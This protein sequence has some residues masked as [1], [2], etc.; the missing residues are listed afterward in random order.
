MLHHRYR[1]TFVGFDPADTN[2]WYRCIPS[3]G[4]GGGAWVLVS[5]VSVAVSA[6]K[7]L[8]I[9][10]QNF[11]IL[12]N[13]TNFRKSIGS[14]L[15]IGSIGSVPGIGRYWKWSIGIGIGNENVVSVH[16]LVT[17]IK[18][19]WDLGTPQRTLCAWQL[20]TTVSLKLWILLCYFAPKHKCHAPITDARYTLHN[21]LYDE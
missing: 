20:A 16:P 7:S 8:K 13:L 18:I 6:T 12:W 3:I 9:H 15:G 21:V 19:S 2:T 1:Y 11:K 14:V 4:I 5:V 17:D 10:S